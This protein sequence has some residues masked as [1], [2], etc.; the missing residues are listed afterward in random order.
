MWVIWKITKNL[1][2]GGWQ[3]SVARVVWWRSCALFSIRTH[4][5]LLSTSEFFLSSEHFFIR[6]VPPRNTGCSARK[7]EEV[8]IRIVSKLR[9]CWFYLKWPYHKLWKTVW[10]GFVYT[11]LSFHFNCYLLKTDQ[12]A[13]YWIATLHSSR[14]ISVDQSTPGQKQIISLYN[15]FF[16]EL[17]LFEVW[18]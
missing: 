1:T 18:F 13:E 15:H 6:L 10:N 9:R 3:W 17:R 14:I 16:D 5:I 7:S 2:A 4:A 11:F 8:V 12:F